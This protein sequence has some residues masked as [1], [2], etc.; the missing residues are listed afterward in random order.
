MPS[1]FAKKERS[2]D[3]RPVPLG[4]GRSWPNLIA[5]TSLPTTW[6]TRNGWDSAQSR[7][8]FS[9]DESEAMNNMRRI[10][11]IPPPPLWTKIGGDCK[12]PDL[13]DLTRAN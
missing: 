9:K 2:D 1:R 6:P 7:R 12:S 3:L 4:H 8:F 5:R 13:L 11:A 10:K